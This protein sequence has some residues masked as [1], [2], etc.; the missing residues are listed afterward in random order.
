MARTTA[1]A[2]EKVLGYNYDGESDLSPY[3]DTAANIVDQAVACATARN[4]VISSGTA[5][6]ME[7]WLAAHYYLQMDPLYKSKTTG[8]ASA[9]FADQDY[10][11]QALQLD[12][13]GCLAGILSG[14]RASLTWG[15]KTDAEKLDYDQRN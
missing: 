10:S 9:S 12:G 2:V 11:K 5:A 15:G 13:S 1:T 3:I 8:R 4:I 7:M 6:L 14:K